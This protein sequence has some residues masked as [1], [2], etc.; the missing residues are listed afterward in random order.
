MFKVRTIAG[1]LGGAACI[2][3]VIGAFAITLTGARSAEPAVALPAPALREGA[4]APG[5]SSRTEE[6]GGGLPDDPELGASRRHE[7]LTVG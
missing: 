4:P 2:A 3:A 7:R 5:L 1:P 6:P